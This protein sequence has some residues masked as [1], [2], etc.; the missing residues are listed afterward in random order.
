MSSL[1]AASISRVSL[2]TRKTGIFY[3]PELDCLRF[4]AFLA[5][6]VCHALP[7][8]INEYLSKGVP[9]VIASLAA[10][11]SSAGAFGVDLFFLLSAYLITSLL[12]RERQ[13][14]GRIDLRSFYLRRILRIWPLYFF[15]L[16][17]T[18][19]W[20][21]FQPTTGMPIRYLVAYLLLAGN[22]MTAIYGPPPSFMSILWSVSVEEQFYLCWPVL[23][24]ATSR[25]AMAWVAGV[26]V[27]TAWITRISLARGT[28]NA[29]TVWPNT[30]ARLD[31][32]GFGI[33]LAA[34]YGAELPNWKFHRRACLLAVGLAAWLL[35]GHYAG[36]TSVYTILGYPVMTLGSIAIFLA[37]AG[38]QIQSR[39]LVYLG[40]ISYGLYVYHVLSLT[41][42]RLLFGGKMG[43]LVWFSTATGLALLFTTVLAALSYAF[44]E[45]PFLN[46]KKRF[47]YVQSRPV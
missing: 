13:A 45:S 12:L 19:I 35:A 44:L 32:I 23:L 3:R 30:L 28:L 5:V 14:T 1:S 11:T 41:V 39:T 15:A 22:W 8:N 34:A 31:A 38:A 16:A 29:Y 21:H 20:S 25:K 40:K 43:H 33:L 9:R 47:T 18:P 42:V 17:I 27:G 7:G 46:L 26:L 10:A 36:P 24:K 37:F 2:P 4:F 6:F